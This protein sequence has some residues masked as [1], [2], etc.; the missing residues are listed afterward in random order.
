MLQV[1]AYGSAQIMQVSPA[2]RSVES[3]TQRSISGFKLVR[4]SGSRGTSGSRSRELWPCYLTRC[5]CIWRSDFDNPALLLC[6]DWWCGN[7]FRKTGGVERSI[8]WIRSAD[9]VKQSDQLMPRNYPDRLPLW[10]LCRRPT[11]GRTPQCTNGTSVAPTC[12]C[13]PSGPLMRHSSR[14]S[15]RDL[16]LDCLVDSQSFMFMYYGMN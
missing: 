10:S 15:R 11:T 2:F 16:W 8:A 3:P 1:P 13:A 12:P 7:R 5:V 4:L 9:A 14:T 6:S